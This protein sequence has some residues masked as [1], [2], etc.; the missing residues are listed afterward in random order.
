M[1]ERSGRILSCKSE[2]PKER[3]N[4]PL[5]WFI[6]TYTHSPII[7][8]TR[9]GF[10]CFQWI[11]CCR[12]G[13][14]WLLRIGHKRHCSF[15]L[16][17]SGATPSGGKQTLP[18][19]HGK[20]QVGGVRPLRNSHQGPEASCWQPCA[21]TTLVTDTSAFLQPPDDCSRRWHRVPASLLPSSWTTEIVR[22]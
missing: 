13:G 21:W 7:P 5:W 11:E 15:F 3:R 8:P 20:I 18:Q 22:W 12:N 4:D 1:N 2:S 10:I 14:L 9:S 19:P 17:V 16:A 6:N